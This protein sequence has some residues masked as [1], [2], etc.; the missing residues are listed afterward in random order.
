M[1]SK[2]SKDKKKKTINLW[3]ILLLSLAIGLGSTIGYTG[4]YVP[5]GF[6][7]DWTYR[8]YVTAGV[9]WAIAYN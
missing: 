4:S 7:S 5:L 6:T 2:L 3:G 9:Y 1:E 8:S